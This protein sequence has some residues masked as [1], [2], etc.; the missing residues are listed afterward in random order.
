MPRVERV[1]SDHGQR[2]GREQALVLDDVVEVLVV[3]P[4]QDQVVE[5]AVR[6]VNAHLRAVDGVLRVRVLSKVFR[7]DYAGVESTADYS[8]DILAT[9]LALH[10]V[11]NAIY[12][13]RCRR[14]RPIDLE[15]RRRTG[16]FLG[17]GLGR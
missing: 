1:I 12:R 17:R 11:K 13:G 2:L 14:R 16:A 15:L 7:E 3:T 9:L 10:R 6:G 4:G 5:A 8:L